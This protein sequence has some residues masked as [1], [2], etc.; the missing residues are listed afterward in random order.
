MDMKLSDIFVLKHELWLKYLFVSFAIKDNEVRDILYEFANIEFRHLKWLGQKLYE[1][2][3]EFTLNRD[4]INIAKNTNYEYFEYLIF[5]TQQVLK[6]YDIDDDLFARMVSD[7]YYFIEQLKSFLQYKKIEF[8]TAFNKKR[9]YKNKNLDKTSTDALTLFLFEETY[10]EYELIVI[11]FYMQIKTDNKLLA[12]VYQDLID[13][14]KFHLKSFGI[15]L[16]EMG[17]LSIPRVVPKEVYEVVDTKQFILDGIEEEKA[18][19]EECKMLAQAIKD[20]E[21]SKFFDLINY[22]EDYHIKLMEKV[23]QYL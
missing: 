11:Y 3:E 20:E 14:S 1:N 19:R 7:E 5:E 2:N 18:A 10:K 6:Q 8:I 4:M 16:S 21:L 12:D 15:M 13:E 17:L 22:Q 9:V 23:C